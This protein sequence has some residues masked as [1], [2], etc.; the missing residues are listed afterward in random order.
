MST[1]GL[2]L[3]RSFALDVTNS[4]AVIGTDGVIG[5]AEVNRDSTRR[6]DP[7]ELLP[8]LSAMDNV[9]AV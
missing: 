7:R 4:R 5:Y 8:G 2:V 6:P 1:G 9:V 3:S